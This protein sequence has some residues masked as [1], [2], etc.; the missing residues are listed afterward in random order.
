MLFCFS[1][2]HKYPASLQIEISCMQ[3]HYT[4]KMDCSVC[5]MIN[6]FNKHIQAETNTQIGPYQATAQGKSSRQSSC[7]LA[8]S[9]A[10][11]DW[12]QLTCSEVEVIKWHPTSTENP[13]VMV[14]FVIYKVYIYC[15]IIAPCE[16]SL[17]IISAATEIKTIK[18]IRI[19]SLL[20][21]CE[22]K[23]AAFWCNCN[24]KVFFIVAGTNRIRS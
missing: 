15:L 5:V 14:T 21:F 19:Y 24:D 6:H 18:I 9:K 7:T 17:W 22:D 11:L 1:Y 23:S 16:T 13:D 20:S 8:P 4:D 3:I 2:H 12:V 10:K